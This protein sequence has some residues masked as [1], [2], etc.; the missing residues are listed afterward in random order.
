MIIVRK[1]D[2]FCNTWEGRLVRSNPSKFII[3]LL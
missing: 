3:L 1:E 2:K